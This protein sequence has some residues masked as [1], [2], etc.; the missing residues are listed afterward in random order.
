LGDAVVAGAIRGGSA[1]GAVVATPFVWRDPSAIP[2]RPWVYG[3]LLLRG[4]VAAVIAPGG[5][6]KTTFL[7]GTSLALS[8]ARLLLGK[9]TWDGPQRVWIWNLEDDMDELSRSIQA[10]AKHFGLTA[11]D[12]GDRLYVDS[13]ME[14]TGLCTAVEEDG[15]FKLLA[16]VY[17]AITQELIRRGIDVL[18]IDPFVS[19]HQVEENANSKIDAIAKAW[20]RVAKAAGCAIVLVHHTSKA[21]AAEVTTLSA[22]GAKALTDAC[23]SALVLNR[24]TPEEAE[25]LGIQGDDERR[26]Y[27]SVMDDKHNRAP[28]EAADWY[29]LVSV[30][31]GNGGLGNGDSVGVAEPW[32]PPD[33]FE[34]LTGDHLL[35]VQ[36]AIAE[37]E[38]RED[39][40][41]PA[42]AGFA[43][44]K[45]LGLDGNEKAPR[46][47]IRKLLNTWIDKG[48]LK[49]VE[50]DDSKRKPRKWIEVD[51]WQNDTSAPPK[52]GGAPQGGAVE[53]I[54]CS[55]TTPSPMGVVGGASGV[56]GN[57][58][59]EQ[60]AG[61]ASRRPPIF[62]ADDDSDPAADAFLRGERA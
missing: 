28:A 11:A 5:V 52:K 20:G 13:A 42:W 31:L 10:A 51:R 48:A 37:G 45:V 21:G 62:P 50:R 41:S 29:Y 9:T 34:G 39:W 57:R 59:V 22:R 6:G 32:S 26:R 15:Q 61:G 40:Q 44:A 49:T 1:P 38:F 24:M 7:C 8:T 19:S 58:P 12:I 27:F 4:T 47:R 14:G 60:T 56:A 36:M 43:V 23:R 2:L 53:P 18:I 25:K 46:S 16:P 54:F 55:T 30:D 35:R 33:P 17:D 3:R